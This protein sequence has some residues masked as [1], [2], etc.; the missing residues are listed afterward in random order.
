MTRQERWK[1]VGPFS[2]HLVP[3]GEWPLASLYYN[4][5]FSRIEA[6]IFPT[7]DKN[8]GV[9]VRTVYSNLEMAKRDVGKIIEEMWEGELEY[10][11]DSRKLELVSWE[12]GTKW[13][14]GAPN[15]KRT[16]HR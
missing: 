8:K 1:R 10:I 4:E 5:L 6:T 12:A 9:A 7:G 16:H 11:H 2:W 14:S 3:D 13:S 15:G